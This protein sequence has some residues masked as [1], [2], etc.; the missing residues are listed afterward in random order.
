MTSN[1]LEAI[2][3]LKSSIERL[4]EQ[5]FSNYGNTVSELNEAIELLQAGEVEEEHCICQECK[6]GYTLRK[7]MEYS[8]TPPVSTKETK[9]SKL[10]KL[11]YRV[12]PEVNIL[13]SVVLDLIDLLEEEY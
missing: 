2:E 8:I 10:M 5:G 3:L 6:P 1:N 11:K 9:Q 7:D 4:Q 12:T 13:A